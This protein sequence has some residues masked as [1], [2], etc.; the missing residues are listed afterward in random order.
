MIERKYYIFRVIISLIIGLPTLILHPY[1]YGL[2]QNIA[3]TNFFMFS[4]I[5]FILIFLNYNLLVLHINRA[6]T[7]KNNLKYIGN[8]FIS[9]MVILLFNHFIIKGFIP[10]IDSYIVSKYLFLTPLIL[11]TFS[12]SYIFS[13]TLLYKVLTDKIKFKSNNLL[14]IFGTCTIFCLLLGIVL[15]VNITNFINNFSLYFCLFLVISINYNH[16]HNLFSGMFGISLS[17]LLFNI[18]TLISF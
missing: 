1:L 8:S 11:I 4:F 15:P 7:Y 5:S 12:F 10:L 13:Y 3:L 16:S 2:V 18:L 14:T 9:G 17:L 6:R